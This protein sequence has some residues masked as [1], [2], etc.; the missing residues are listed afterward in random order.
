MTVMDAPKTQ[1]AFHFNA[2]DKLDY[3][4]RFVRKA[5]RHDARVTL[6]APIERLRQLSA[7]LWKQAGHDFL[8]HAVQGDAPELFSRAPVILVES[9]ESS[10]HCDVLLN[11][12]AEIPQGF[13]RFARVVEVVASFDE[14]DRSQAR[15]RWRSYQNAG[16]VIDRRDLVLNGG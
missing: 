15:A 5:L 6:V 16:Y 7:R 2:P 1:V 10:P 9:A 8:A 3:A 13:E 11:L 14:M 12:G 4:C